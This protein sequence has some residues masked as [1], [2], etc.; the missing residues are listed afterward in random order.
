MLH[1]IIIFLFVTSWAILPGWS[2][3]YS[4]TYRYTFNTLEELIEQVKEPQQAA[5]FVLPLKLVVDY[6]VITDGS[7]YLVS[8]KQISAEGLGLGFH[9]QGPIRAFADISSGKVVLQADDGHFG[10]PSWLYSYMVG[11][12]LPSDPNHITYQLAAPDS[13]YTVTFCDTIPPAIHPVTPIRGATGGVTAIRSQLVEWD[14]MGWQRIQ[15]FPAPWPDFPMGKPATDQFF[16]MLPDEA[17]MWQK[18]KA[19]WQNGQR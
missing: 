12:Q 8:G 13:G 7:K 5:T 11:K 15:R 10:A 17:T 19:D 1:R 2:Q 18:V 16:K 9:Q 14:L 4:A 6:T 3:I